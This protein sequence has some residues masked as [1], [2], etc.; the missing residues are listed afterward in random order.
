MQHCTFV[1][2]IAFNLE[3]LQSVRSFKK[4]IFYLFYM[5]NYDFL[6]FCSRGTCLSNHNG[7]IIHFNFVDFCL[8]NPLMNAACEPGIATSGLMPLTLCFLTDPSFL[9]DTIILG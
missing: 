2:D 5:Q 6:S 1:R 4:S 8:G 3:V 9:F 7:D